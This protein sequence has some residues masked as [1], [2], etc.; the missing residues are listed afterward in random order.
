MIKC[1][2]K[3]YIISF[4]NKIIKWIPFENRDNAERFLGLLL[5]GRYNITMLIY[6]AL[7][8]NHFTSL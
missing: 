1:N 3:D 7:K 5:V 8:R 2:N 6:Y 4:Y